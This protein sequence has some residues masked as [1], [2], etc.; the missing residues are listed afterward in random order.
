ML[1]EVSKSTIRSMGPETCA[2]AE[3]IITK[4][5]MTA[6]AV[7]FMFLSSLNNYNF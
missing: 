3:K 7:L 1:A 6:A 4:T 2:A 5:R